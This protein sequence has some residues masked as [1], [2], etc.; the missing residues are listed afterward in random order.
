MA[1]LLQLPKLTKTG[2]KTRK[3]GREMKKTEQDI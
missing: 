1:Y 2:I 3:A